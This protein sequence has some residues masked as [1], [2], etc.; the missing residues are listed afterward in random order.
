M[1]RSLKALLPGLLLGVWCIAADAATWYYFNGSATQSAVYFFDKDTVTRQGDGVTLWVKYVRDMAG[2]S[3]REGSYSTTYRVTYSCSRRTSRIT[4]VSAYDKLG[5]FLRTTGPFVEDDVVPE[6][7]GEAVLTVACS[8]N[9]PN[10]PSDSTYQAIA[11]DVFQ[12]AKNY[13]D[14]KRAAAADPAPK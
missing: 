1:R 8:K 7:I 3:D 2:P 13:F 6:S 4:T 14:Y 11:V 5:V 10:A 9:F 12:Y